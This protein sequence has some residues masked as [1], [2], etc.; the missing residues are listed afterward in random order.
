MF[1]LKCVASNSSVILYGVQS[2]GAKHMYLTIW[3]DSACSKV[4]KNS[5]NLFFFFL[6]LPVFNNKPI[7][8]LFHRAHSKTVIKALG[9]D[10]DFF[11]HIQ[12]YKYY[13]CNPTSCCSSVEGAFRAT[14]RIMTYL[15]NGEISLWRYVDP[16]RLRIVWINCISQFV[17]EAIRHINNTNT[18][19][20]Q[21]QRAVGDCRVMWKEWEIGQCTASKFVLKWT[22]FVSAF[23]S[24]RSEHTCTPVSH[25]RY[26]RSSG[27]RLVVCCGSGKLG[28]TVIIVCH[29][30]KIRLHLIRVESSEVGEAIYS[31]A[32][33]VSTYAARV[34]FDIKWETVLRPVGTLLNFN[35]GMSPQQCCLQ[36]RRAG[37][38]SVRCS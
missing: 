7:W 6:F 3:L 4:I 22:L 1:H 38:V 36:D 14:M 10:L 17:S 33:S 25:S 2:N 15:W 26:W 8:R 28:L 27:V 32:L 18:S 11:R 13:S 35:K 24:I 21:T 16:G 9:F 34:F 30:N 12:K 37:E 5:S 23:T 20:T 29:Q 31:R 19:R